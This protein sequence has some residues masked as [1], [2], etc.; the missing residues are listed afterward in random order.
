VGANSS[1]IYLNVVCLPFEKLW[2]VRGFL[3]LGGAGCCARRDPD[4]LRRRGVLSYL[5]Y[6]ALCAMQKS[7]SSFVHFARCSGVVLR[8]V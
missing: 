1:A 7:C 4:S 2:L 3:R 6:C 8:V 5:Y